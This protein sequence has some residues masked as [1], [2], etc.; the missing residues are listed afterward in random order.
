MRTRETLIQC[1]AEIIDREGL[2]VASLSMI[3]TR[4]GMSNGA[5]HFHFGSKA[6]L[7]D[8]VE[9]AALLRLRAVT[10]EASPGGPS[11]LQH[12]V[13]VTHGLAR[14]LSGDKV[15]RAGFTLS[16]DVAR[17]RRT[18][19]R[20]RWQRWVEG[21]V[22]RAVAAGELRPGVEPEG[23]VAAV[24]GAIVG[25]EVLGA[26]NAAWISHRTVTQFWRLLLPCLASRDVLAKIRAD[27]TG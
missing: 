14:E 25:F 18:D 2:A 21:Q 20:D 15:L 22:A 19:L 8:A 1:A 9:E 3:S 26:Q 23:A 4:A 17:P 7:T 5:L 13:D 24:V 6:A 12:L 27:G 10:Q 16:G 11:C